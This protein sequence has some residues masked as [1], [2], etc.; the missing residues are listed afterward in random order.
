MVD[1]DVFDFE[2]VWLYLTMDAF[3]GVKR[4]NS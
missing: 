1:D 4:E 2:L 3:H